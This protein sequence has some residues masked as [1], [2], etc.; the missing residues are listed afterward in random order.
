MTVFSHYPFSFSKY[1]VAGR[2]D[3]EPVDSAGGP[4]AHHSDY[5]QV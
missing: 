1:R 5:E 4:T 2:H 3:L